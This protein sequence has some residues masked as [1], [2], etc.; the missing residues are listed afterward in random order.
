MHRRRTAEQALEFLQD[1]AA[2]ESDGEFSDSDNEKINNAFASASKAEVS[3][4][5]KSTD[6]EEEDIQ[7]STVDDNQPANLVSHVDDDNNTPVIQSRDGSFWQTSTP[8][9]VAVGRRQQQ[10][11]VKVRAG[12]TSYATCRVIDGSPLSSFRLLFNE[13]MLRHIQKCTIAEAQRVTNDTK[14]TVTLDELDKFIGLVI[15]RGVIAGRNLPIKSLWDQSWGCPLFNAT[16]PRRRFLEIMKY[17]R[18]DLKSERKRQLETD[19]FC[20]ASSIWDPFIENCQKSYNP[21]SNIT[22]DEQLL[23]CKARC[24][25]IQYMANKPDKFGLKFWMAAEVESKYLYNGFPYLGKDSTRS[26]DVSVPT[27]VVM[28]L[29]SPLFKKGYNVTCDNYFTSL[30][31]TLRLAEQHCSLVGTIRQNRREVPTVLKETQPL[32]ESTILEYVG[33]T[34][35]TITSYQCKKSQSVNILSSLHKDVTIPERNNPK[36]KPETILF[37]NETKVGVDVLDQMSR[38]YSVKAGSRRWPIHVFYNVIDMALINGWILYKI[39]S[40]TKISRRAF[41]QKVCEELTGSNPGSSHRAAKTDES[42]K[43]DHLGSPL[44][45]VRRTCSIR[46]CKNRTT[47]LCFLC[48]KPICG[49]CGKKLCATCMTR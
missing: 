5:E 8:S 18:F 49:K 15:A 38:Q 31:L 6:D 16:M 20:L 2:D 48:K 14:W 37:Y 36:R 1:I 24:K 7:D 29:M 47:D 32:H 42:S 19:K 11:V 17:L 28:K 43:V 44:P 40:K 9:Q 23:P 26:G 41:I 22:I 33:A 27:D 13:P 10:N 34:A 35:V 21:N 12:P 30:D 4:S 25:F 46:C 3:D 39:I 45:K